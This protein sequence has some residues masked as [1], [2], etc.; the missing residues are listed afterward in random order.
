M[1]LKTFVKVGHISNLSDARYCAGFGVNL[2][3]FNLFD[4]SEDQI[5][6][7]LAKE[8]MG[9]VAVENFVLECG[10]AD[11]EFVDQ[12]INET[13]IDYVQVNHPEIANDLAA[14]GRQVILKMKINSPEESEIAEQIISRLDTNI[15]FLIVD[16]DDNDASSYTADLVK[17]VEIPVLKAFDNTKENIVTILEEGHFAGIALKGSVEDKPGFKD[18][19]ELA[20]ILETLE[21][22]S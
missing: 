20:D 21:V 7:E 18:Y 10:N 9:W 22:D 1:Q 6:V 4:Q 2:L 15:K 17:N 3:G 5:S 16:S 8:I 12:M 14:D 19:D 13:G 11:K